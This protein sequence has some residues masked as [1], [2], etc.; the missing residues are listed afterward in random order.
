[1]LSIRI[2]M[3]FYSSFVK[4]FIIVILNVHDFQVYAPLNDWNIAQTLFN[5]WSKDVMSEEYS[6]VL[7]M[8]LSSQT[9]HSAIK[10]TFSKRVS[11]GSRRTVSISNKFSTG[12]DLLKRKCFSFPMHPCHCLINVTLYKL[13]QIISINIYFNYMRPSYS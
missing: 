11:N 7:R 12:E 1:M 6:I 3:Q 8:A 10:Q 13:D 5:Q 2:T 4:C 9:S